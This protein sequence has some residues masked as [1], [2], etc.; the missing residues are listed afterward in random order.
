M[1]KRLKER[2]AHA[3]V[4]IFPE[5]YNEL[6]ANFLN[7]NHLLA[8]GH[9]T[10]IAEV[11]EKTGCKEVLIDRFA[12]EHIVENAVKKKHLDIHLTQRVRAEE[13][14][15]VAGASILARAAFL[16]GLKRTGAPWEITL[17]KGAGNPVLT[18]GKNL[19]RH[20]G[21]SILPRIAKMHFK[22]AR[23]ILD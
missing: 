11:T 14:P 10:A 12:S 16:E 15:V 5:R 21:P 23:E 22:T 7:L 9:A 6:Y 8:W 13:D 17:P 18:M 19:V 4:I 3:L 2:F 20:H 1:S